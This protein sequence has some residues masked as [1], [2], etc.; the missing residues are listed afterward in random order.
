MKVGKRAYYNRRHRKACYRRDTDGAWR[1]GDQHLR[2]WEVRWRTN[3]PPMSLN[4]RCTVTIRMTK[5]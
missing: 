5:E 4:C 1:L 2:R 3:H